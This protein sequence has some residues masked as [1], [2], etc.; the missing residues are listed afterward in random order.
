MKQYLKEKF[1]LIW[2]LAL[3]FVIYLL[4]FSLWHLKLEPLINATLLGVLIVLFFLFFD[5]RKWSNDRRKLTLL[6]DELKN[7]TERLEAVVL[8]D[9]NLTDIVRIW[10]HQMKVPLASIDLMVQTNDVDNTVLKNQVFQVDNYLNILLEYLRLNNISTD[11]RFDKFDAKDVVTSLVKKYASQFIAKDLTV[12]ITGNWILVTDKRWFSVA[13][14]QIINNAVKYTNSGSVKFILEDKSLTIEDTGIGILSE[15][16]PRLFEHG[17]TG[18][19][20]RLEKKSTGLGL[21][22]SKTI[23]DKLDFQITVES[24]VDKGT[25][26]R[27]NKK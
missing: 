13:L 19:N 20:G 1:F 3:V 18:Y 7:V 15:D 5:Y 23:L 2:T 22:L 24:Q 27:I 8:F 17:F 16:I 9:K 4:T 6:E 10:S 12:E 11:Y 14:E 26:V 21:Y 25:K